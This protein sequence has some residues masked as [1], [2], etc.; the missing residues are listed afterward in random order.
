MPPNKHTNWSKLE[1]DKAAL[2]LGRFVDR[3]EK[4][5]HWRHLMAKRGAAAFA[6]LGTGDLFDH[7]PSTDIP[8]GRS[9]RNKHGGWGS[10]HRWN[11]ARAITETF[12]EKLTGLD[13]PKT[14]LVA[15]DATWEERTAAVWADRFIEGNMHQ[16]Q[17]NFLDTWDLGR[18]AF[19]VAGVATG[20]VA[21]R[22]EPDFVCK[23]VRSI[24]RSTL[25]TF[26]DPGDYAFG[27]PLT[28]V[29]VTWD[30]P[31]Y[32]VEDDR[33]KG[34]TDHIMASAL[35][36]PHHRETSEYGACLDTPMVK[37]ISAWRLPFGS[38]KGR[39]AVI[40][41]GKKVIWED[42]EYPTPPLAFFGMK[43][44]VGDNF[45]A[46]NFIEIMMGALELA[47]ECNAIFENTMRRLSQTYAIYDSANTSPS[48]WLNAKDVVALAYDGNKGGQPPQIIQPGLA[49]SD[50]F[51]YQD[52]NIEVA[53]ALTGVSQM[54]V[55]SQSPA[56]TDSGR[57]KRLEAALLPERFAKIQRNW[58]HFMAVDVG[59]NQLRAARQIGKV[60]PNWQV[61]WPG[62]DFEA[63]V[64]VKALNLDEKI[65]TVRAYAVSEQKNTPAD[66]A[67]TAQEWL[68][69]KLITLEQYNII[70]SGAYDTP[71]EAKGHATQR[72]YVAKV[73]DEILHGDE[74]LVGDENRY[75]AEE[76]MP[77]PPWI[78]P[79]SALA[80]AFE[81]YLQAM[82]DKMPQ[83]R[84]NLLRRFLEDCDALLAKQTQTEAVQQ[85]MNVS[86]EAGL[87]EVAPA[88]AGGAPPPMPG[89][90]PMGAPLSA[91]QG[92]TA[93]PAMPPGMPPGMPMN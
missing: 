58:R 22:T 82:I 33:Y 41:G 90:P 13:E 79:A 55:S 49:H 57:A 3:H 28:F 66:R 52:K 26:V 43:R 56:G 84:R 89:A 70:I 24:L 47:D 12:T 23:R 65:Y 6:G 42:W 5:T 68:D 30:N 86:V 39:E 11:Y 64:G 59:M 92:P 45:W 16:G 38:F 20:T 75:M 8:R 1:P 18:H 21:I 35:V 71:K 93:A 91:D 36:P 7:L 48:E 37:R 80:Q 54:H 25:N 9:R 87:G 85:N 78:D 15:T 14:Q 61:T 67:Q 77:P 27:Q 29:D 32:L 62:Q 19:L 74:D 81:I 60:E 76:Y 53:H 17:G 46:E 31:E 69:Q 63:K 72:R 51:Q 34:M 10:K 44:A 40:I 50:Y 2:E 4:A 73:V 83:N 88:L